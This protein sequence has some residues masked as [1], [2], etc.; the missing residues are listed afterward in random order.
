MGLS[1]SQAPQTQRVTWQDLVVHKGTSNLLTS[2]Q[3]EP[4][5][6]PTKSLGPPDSGFSLHRPASAMGDGRSQCR[7]LDKDLRVAGMSTPAV[8]LAQTLSSLARDTIFHYLFFHVFLTLS[9]FSLLINC[10]KLP[11]VIISL[12][13]NEDPLHLCCVRGS[14]KY[15]S[16]R[17][18]L[19][20]CCTLFI[21]RNINTV[22]NYK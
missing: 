15:F 4:F 18:S 5:Q 20:D 16:R 3:G 6:H 11:W 2:N 19:A 22:M 1:F 10:R 13:S 12:P 17:S 7:H 8:L 21:G 14:D 9:S